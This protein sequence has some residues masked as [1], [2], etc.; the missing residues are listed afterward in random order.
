MGAAA[1]KLRATWQRHQT[2][3]RL[4]ALHLAQT[5]DLPELALDDLGTLLRDWPTLQYLFRE[6]L[7]DL[8]RF[9]ASLGAPHTQL[10]AL[11]LT[12]LQPW[13]FEV[14]PDTLYVLWRALLLSDLLLL[15]YWISGANVLPARCVVLGGITVGLQDRG[16]QHASAFV[17]LFGAAP[18]Q[19]DVLYQ[20]G[21][22]LAE[23]LSRCG[24]DIDAA[25]LHRQTP[26]LAQFLEYD[27]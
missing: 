25:A 19:D 9:W 16:S 15:R 11:R 6:P 21:W 13:P 22:Q 20:E 18:I 7:E 5:H 17:Q 23:L 1:L 26:A 12:G 10:P 24:S 2:R 3:R 4:S 14:K 8:W 27:R